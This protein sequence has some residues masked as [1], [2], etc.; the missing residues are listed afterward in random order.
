M[1]KF[2]GIFIFLFMVLCPI[3]IVS[4][5]YTVLGIRK[6]KIHLFL[7]YKIKPRTSR[8]RKKGLERNGY[9]TLAGFEFAC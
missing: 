8:Q 1:G 7:F 2:G 9:K 3:S 5:V 4:I 6:N